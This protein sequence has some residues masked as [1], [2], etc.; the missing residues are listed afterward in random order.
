MNELFGTGDATAYD[1][2]DDEP[3]ETTW[4]VPAVATTP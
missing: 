3:D 2:L 1:A 4:N